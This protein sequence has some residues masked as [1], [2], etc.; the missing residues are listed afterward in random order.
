[1][2]TQDAKQEDMYFVQYMNFYD[3]KSNKYHVNGQLI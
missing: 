3:F 2:I 1:M